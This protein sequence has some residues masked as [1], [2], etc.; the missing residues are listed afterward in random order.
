MLL[1]RIVD[2]YVLALDEL[3]KG[4]IFE[5]VGRHCAGLFSCQLSKLPCR[6]RARIRK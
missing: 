2:V 5:L 3:A 4:C 1:R 6:L